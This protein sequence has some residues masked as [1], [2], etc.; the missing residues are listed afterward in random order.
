MGRRKGKSKQSGIKTHQPKKGRVIKTRRRRRRS[1]A[2]PP[3]TFI[4]SFIMQ[5][6][7]YSW[8]SMLI[9]LRGERGEGRGRGGHH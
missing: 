5:K 2:Q 1:I 3:I 7:F 8:H 4:H 9:L 6:V